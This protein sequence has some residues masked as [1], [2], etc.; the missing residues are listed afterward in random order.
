MDRKEV[1][2]AFTNEE[3]AVKKINHKSQT[4]RKHRKRIWKRTSIQNR[5]I[6]CTIQDQRNRQIKM[7]KS[8]EQIS[9]YTI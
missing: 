2:M 5:Q 9:Y 1:F 6:T 7:G 8:F 4:K 3:N